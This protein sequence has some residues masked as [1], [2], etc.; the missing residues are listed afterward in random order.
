MTQTELDQ[1][2]YYVPHGWAQYNYLCNCRDASQKMERMESINTNDFLGFREKMFVDSLQNNTNLPRVNLAASNSPTSRLIQILQTI[3]TIST[4]SMGCDD[5]N[6]VILPEDLKIL[7][8]FMME[9]RLM[10]KNTTFTTSQYATSIIAVDTSAITQPASVLERYLGSD[11]YGQ[12][13]G[14]CAVR[15]LSAVCI[16]ELKNITP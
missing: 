16:G 6:L 8:G 15:H 3:Q 10:Y 5:A 1:F 2:V 7:P 14:G 13:V 4:N 9:L 11:V 12:S